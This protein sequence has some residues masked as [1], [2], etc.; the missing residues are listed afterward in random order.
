MWKKVSAVLVALV[1]LVVIL[2]ARGIGSEAGKEIGNC[3]S[4]RCTLK[5]IRG[6]DHLAQTLGA[7]GQRRN[8]FPQQARQILG[9][10]VTSRDR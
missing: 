3:E 2:F 5:L 9:S 4:A 8:Q 6:S 1:A 10:L 7:H